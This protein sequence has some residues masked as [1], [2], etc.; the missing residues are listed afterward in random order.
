M[1]TLDTPLKEHLEMNRETATQEFEA[2]PAGRWRPGTDKAPKSGK[3]VQF[4]EDVDVIMVRSFKHHN[5]VLMLSDG[6][7]SCS[8]SKCSVF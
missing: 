6:S 4:S 2:P 3:K 7:W 8:E 1:E 5:R